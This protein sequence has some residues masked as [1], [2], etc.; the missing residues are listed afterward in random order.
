MIYFLKIEISF[1]LTKSQKN[2]QKSLENAIAYLLYSCKQ[3]HEVD[4]F[5]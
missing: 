3:E 4:F 5:R 2:S 1:K